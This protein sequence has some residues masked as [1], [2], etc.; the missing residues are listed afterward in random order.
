LGFLIDL[1]KR[2]GFLGV[3]LSSLFI[4]VAW[5]KRGV[6]AGLKL[7]SALLLSTVLRT[8]VSSKHGERRKNVLVVGLLETLV[9]SSL[10]S[11]LEIEENWNLVS[12]LPE[13]EEWV[14][15]SSLE[16]GKKA[17]DILFP[18]FEEVDEGNAED[19]KIGL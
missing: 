18:I 15:S 11:M 6:V 14:C 7:M 4:M 5:M 16:I 19:W 12:K 8:T 10:L 1:V 9:S 17:D 3:L 2:L 13:T